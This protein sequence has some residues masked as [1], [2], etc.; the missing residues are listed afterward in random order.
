M[1]HSL[2][3]KNPN[4]KNTGCCN[5]E[6]ENL[7]ASGKNKIRQRSRKNKKKCDLLYIYFSSILKKF[8]IFVLSFITTNDPL[9]IHLQHKYTR[10]ERRKTKNYNIT[11]YNIIINYCYFLYK[12]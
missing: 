5:Q 4:T 11:V 9:Q 3:P 7:E 6:E 8:K 2:E 1:V 12:Q 10:K